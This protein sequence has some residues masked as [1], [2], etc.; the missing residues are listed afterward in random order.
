MPI[1]QTAIALI[2]GALLIVSGPAAAMDPLPENPLFRDQ[3]VADPSAHV[4]GDT[5]YLY[6]TND[7]GND[8]KY[9]NSRDWRAFSSKDLRTW[10]DHGSVASLDV[11]PWAEGLAWAPGA[12]FHKGS[13]YLIVPLDRT[14]I[15]VAKSASPLG[16]FVDAIGAPLIDKARDENVGAEPIDPALL[17]DDDGKIYLSFGTRTPKIVELS[18]DLTRMVGP[19]RD[20]KIEG[21][22]PGAPYGEAPWLHKRGGLYYFSYST[23]WPG[24]IV[25]A[26]SRDPMGPYSYRGVILDRMN[27]FTNHQA[28]VELD[29]QS[30]L[31]YHN[32]S[33]PGGGD[34]KRSINLDRLDYEP[35]GSIRQVVPTGGG[36]APGLP[37]VENPA[38]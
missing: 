32:H 24:Q 15:G 38:K 3:F 33:L 34:Y 16:P 27:T 6:A 20:V 31:F 35:D 9:W 12:A 36:A 7:S 23:G 14:K 26:T 11:F 25:Y 2:L 30:Y 19:I 5:V 21:A 13:Y 28:I 8:G 4:F 18:D 10:A 37:A 22:P 29:G 17:I 1:I